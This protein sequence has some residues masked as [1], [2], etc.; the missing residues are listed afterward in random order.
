M[1]FIFLAVSLLVASNSYAEINKDY[2]IYTSD[3]NEV[4]KNKEKLMVAKAKLAKQYLKNAQESRKKSPLIHGKSEVVFK[5]GDAIKKDVGAKIGMT[6]NQISEKTYWGK[7]E[8]TNSITD[9]YGKL[10]WWYY[11]HYGNLLFDNDKLIRV[12]VIDNTSHW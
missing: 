10:E 8:I 5:V 7:P 3:S 4:K 2:Y 11:D 9:E 12:D 1:R 6:P